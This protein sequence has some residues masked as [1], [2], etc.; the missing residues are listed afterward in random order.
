MAQLRLYLVVMSRQTGGQRLRP[1]LKPPL[2]SSFGQGQVLVTTLKGSALPIFLH[3]PGEGRRHEF[4]QRRP[5]PRA[6]FRRKLAPE[7][8]RAPNALDDDQ[9]EGLHILRWR[10]RKEGADGGGEGLR[11][12]LCVRQ[13]DG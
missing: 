2:R 13:I 3:Q 4:L 7:L 5:Y 12:T 8:K 6:L 11:I 10:A 1:E 9:R